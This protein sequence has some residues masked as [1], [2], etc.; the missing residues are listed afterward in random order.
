MIYKVRLTQHVK[1]YADIYIECKHINDVLLTA[2]EASVWIEPEWKEDEDTPPKA[3]SP[4]LLGP[5]LEDILDQKVY[6]KKN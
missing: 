3:S 6:K 5:V 1:Q 4:V 2:I